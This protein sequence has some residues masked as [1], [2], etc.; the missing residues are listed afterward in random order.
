MKWFAAF[1][2]VIALLVCGFPMTVQA[3]GDTD[4][5]WVTLNMVNNVDYSD[6]TL[7]GVYQDG[8][9]YVSAA[10]LAR[11]ANAQVLEDTAEQVSLLVFCRE[12][13][14]TPDGKLLDQL[15]GNG[16]TREVDVP[17]IR[18]REKLCISM[19]HVYRYLGI[20]ISFAASA[21][22]AGS[23]EDTLHLFIRC[24]YTLYDAL[25]EFT[26]LMEFYIFQ[27]D[28]VLQEGIHSAIIK[29]TA[30]LDTILIHYDNNLLNHY[31]EVST[32]EQE[33]MSDCMISIVR[34]EGEG[35]S[36]QMLTQTID[37]SKDMALATD[38]TGSVFTLAEKA[39][40]ASGKTAEALNRGAG[41]A[42]GKINELAQAAG[43]Y[44]DTLN[45]YRVFES[46]PAEQVQVLKN[47]LVR[48]A[49]QEYGP[50]YEGNTVM[51]ETAELVQK[52]AEDSLANMTVAVTEA[53]NDSVLAVINNA[54]QGILTKA[55]GWPYAALNAVYTLTTTYA[56][57][58]PVLGEYVGDEIQLTQARGCLDIQ[59]MGLILYLDD[60]QKLT[61][62]DL[63]YKDSKKAAET[64]EY[65]QSDVLLMLKS[66]MAARRLL[67][68][69]VYAN[70]DEKAYMQA[71]LGTCAELA[72]KTANAELIL[73]GYPDAPTDDD[74][75]WISKL[76]P[77]N[78]GG[79][80]VEHNG[81]VYYW[82][83]SPKFY[84]TDATTFA[85]YESYINPGVSNTL[86]RRSESG[87]EQMLM[88]GPGHGS[89]YLFMDKVFWMW[90]N[91]GDGGK[92]Y[93]VHMLNLSEGHDKVIGRGELK[94]LDEVNGILV[95]QDG[96]DIYVYDILED[97]VQ[98]A[99]SDADIIDVHDGY[100]YYQDA[101]G[102]YESVVL[103]RMSTMERKPQKLGQ[104]DVDPSE[105][106]LW[107]GSFT[108]TNIHSQIW[109]D[110]LYMINGIYAGTGYIFQGGQ[111][112]RIKLDGSEKY[113][114]LDGDSSGFTEDDFL[115]YE[116]D[117]HVYVNYE[118]YGS[119]TD[120]EY[121]LVR[122]DM[123]SKQS[124]SA[125]SSVEARRNANNA[126][127]VYY[128]ATGFAWN[129]PELGLAQELLSTGE[130]EALGFDTYI[131]PGGQRNYTEM[132]MAEL[133]GDKLYFSLAENKYAAG[134]DVGWRYSFELD[135]R[136]VFVKNMT[137][138][139]ITKLF[140]Y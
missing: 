73:P 68:D 56:E 113:E 94:G 119:A 123:G 75:T 58:D 122:M 95:F 108:F 91:R 33:L 52:R 46:I 100:I 97:K 87:N 85:R 53:T 66:A 6:M 57:T 120:W 111:L 51:V 64:L 112:G 101:S 12:I 86:M 128:T 81:Y 121:T 31:M 88:L 54:K 47:T 124:A 8:N 77:Q 93:S 9:F 132:G 61:K 2:W 39:A 106:D 65:L 4:P 22:E 130:L 27:L 114:L 92:G 72:Y 15:Q 26:E 17:V 25:G 105:Y 71:A 117:G 67:I 83:I 78:N 18:V 24:P 131:T 38:L 1:V 126:Y 13:I 5:H 63:Y 32:A 136:A 62:N 23:A 96:K 3:Q 40:A 21:D 129:N 16:V 44:F 133:I 109:G 60:F 104:V 107:D 115:V 84:P 110:Y 19:L 20:E 135:H 29:K 34:E 10:D 134:K 125:G 14:I 7:D 137:T 50:L 11:Y 127:E 118:L 80:Y 79:R 45:T 35:Y 74:L 98:I 37:F 138:G 48:I 42:F 43:I 103:Y 59:N 69:T 30:A 102:Q 36:D 89:L 99:D 70:D 41:S 140:D 28:E 116:Q 76:A 90:D 49:N 55:F 82:E 139:V